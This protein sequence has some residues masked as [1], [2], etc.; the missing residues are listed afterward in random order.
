MC[1]N[2]MFLS[3][4]WILIHRNE[5]VNKKSEAA[6]VAHT[7]THRHAYAYADLFTEAQFI[8]YNNKDS[9]SSNDMNEKMGT[10]HPMEKSVPAIEK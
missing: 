3:T 9:E 1:E 10:R 4:E 2:I 7:H 5:I 6:T 8:K